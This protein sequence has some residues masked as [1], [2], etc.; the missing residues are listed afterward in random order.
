MSALLFLTGCGEHIGSLV[1]DL[2]GIEQERE[3]ATEAIPEEKKLDHRGMPEFDPADATE[4]AEDR[5]FRIGKYRDSA[6]GELYDNYYFGL[7]YT[8]PE[9]WEFMPAEEL[10]ELNA[11][12]G[13]GHKEVGEYLK[14]GGS[15][16]DMSAS[17]YRGAGAAA[18][19]LQ[20]VGVVVREMLTP[21]EL[22]R[23]STAYLEDA[24]R[25][26]GATDIAI[27]RGT[28]SFLDEEHPCV[29]VEAALEGVRL[30]QTQVFLIKGSYIA[31]VMAV[32]YRQDITADILAAFSGT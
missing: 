17:H 20:R 12:A 11:A 23:R 29:Y 16:T 21:D 27:R 22:A 28:V 2:A 4:L 1:D 10:A 9:N 8:L 5:S 15:Y 31:N 19:T 32:S 24:L 6:A 18:V 30:Y 13:T 14:E 26:K 25:A 3:R 7:R